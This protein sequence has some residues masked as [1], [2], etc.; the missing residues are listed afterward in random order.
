MPLLGFASNLL[1]IPKQICQTLIL[2]LR[3]FDIVRSVNT[4][5]VGDTFVL[6]SLKNT[7]SLIESLLYFYKNDE[8]GNVTFAMWLQILQIPKQI[9]KTLTF[10]LIVFVL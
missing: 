4:K 8:E 5:H 6:Y 9:Y 2:T 3:V 10:T 1:Q 7:D